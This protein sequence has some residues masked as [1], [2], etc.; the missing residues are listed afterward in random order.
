MLAR[1]VL[2][3]AGVDRYDRRRGVFIPFWN[4]VSAIDIAFS[5]DGARAAYR[6]LMDD[7]LWVSRTDGSDARQLTRPP[8]RAY[9]PHWSADGKWIA[10]MGQADHQPSRIFVV[11]TRAATG[12][13]AASEPP[14]ALL[15]SD[16]VEQGVPSWSPDGRFLV[17]GELRHRR[18]DQEMTIRI[19]DLSTSK[20]SILADSRGKWSP[21]WSPDGRYIV[22]A[23]T[24]FKSLWF[25]DCDHRSWSR[26]LTGNAIDDLTWSADSRFVH[27]SAEATP[28]GGRAL[29][30]ASVTGGSAERLAPE[31]PS[32]VRWSGVAPDGSPL[33]PSTT[34]IEEIY[35]I[36]FR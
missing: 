28:D 2:S 27:F 15:S 10:F 29:F 17:F 3:K 20:E 8:L 16:P 26:R 14:Q 32:P 12:S 11:E 18:S 1:G 30:R 5:R 13:D 9:Q 24:D 33:V 6:N 22:A 35:A 19:L 25:Y 36:H 4:D 23:G 7:T 34:R 21:R 31:P